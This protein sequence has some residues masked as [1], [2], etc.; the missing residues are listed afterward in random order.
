M[1]LLHI[2]KTWKISTCVGNES[3]MID[4]LELSERNLKE[5]IK[6]RKKTET[7]LKLERQKIS[8]KKYKTL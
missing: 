2:R 4:L 1:K 7:P 8:A 6:I 5:V 3:V